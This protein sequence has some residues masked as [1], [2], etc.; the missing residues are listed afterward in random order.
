M[1]HGA[2]GKFGALAMLCAAA[3][4]AGASGSQLSR[5]DIEWLERVTYG[6]TTATVDEYLKLGRRRF[7]SE[8]LPRPGRGRRGCFGFGLSA[9]CGPALIDRPTLCAARGL[10]HSV[11]DRS[12]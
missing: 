2:C 1:K 12:Q 7:L 4:P 3:L 11:C 6:P 5:E 10:V 8:Q 9:G